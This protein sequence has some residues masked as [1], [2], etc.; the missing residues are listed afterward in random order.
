MNTTHTA[1]AFAR[2]AD[3]TQALHERF[4]TRQ[5]AKQAAERVHEEADEVVKAATQNDL[6]AAE[7]EILDTIV[8]AI[9]LCRAVGTTIDRV[10]ARADEVIEKND[11]KTHETH[12]LRFDGKI[13]RRKRNGEPTRR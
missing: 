2:L 5:N 3:S 12:E 4:N 9:G 7:L 10:M 6:E 13:A 11:S 1:A 8:T